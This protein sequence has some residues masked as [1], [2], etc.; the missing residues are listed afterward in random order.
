MNEQYQAWIDANVPNKE[1]AYGKCAEVT[2]AMQSAFPEL[3]RVRGF[4]HCPI[5]GRRTHWWLQDGDEIVDPTSKQHPSNGIGQ[6]QEVKDETEIPTGVCA[7]CGEPVYNGDYFC[8]N[9]CELKT[10]AYLNTADDSNAADNTA[11]GRKTLVG[12]GRNEDGL[13]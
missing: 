7:D 1:A 4:Y 2:L 3:R 11:G 5:W 13:L 9:E 10:V 6:Y 12:K 8:S